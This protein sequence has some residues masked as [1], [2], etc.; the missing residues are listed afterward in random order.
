MDQLHQSWSNGMIVKPEA[1]AEQV[2][3]T[4]VWDNSEVWVDAQATSRVLVD[5]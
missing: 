2:E 3:E 1:A 5:T 4:E